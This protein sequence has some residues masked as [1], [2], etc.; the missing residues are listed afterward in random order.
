MIGC[1]VIDRIDIGTPE[2]GIEK[3]GVIAR[4][5]DQ[6]VIASPADQGVVALKAIKAVAAVRPDQPIA[7]PRPQERDAVWREAPEIGGDELRCRDILEHGEGDIVCP[8]GR[9]VAIDLKQG[10]RTGLHQAYVATAPEGVAA[11]VPAGQRRVEIA[12]PVKTVARRAGWEVGD[13]GQPRRGIGQAGFQRDYVASAAQRQPNAVRLNAPQ[14]NT[15]VT[16][17]KIGGQRALPVF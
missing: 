2:R 15:V 3:I 17:T 11:A 13:P 9:S 14:P 5:A 8:A 10:V 4:S 7:I 12:C 6:A 1:E 16:I